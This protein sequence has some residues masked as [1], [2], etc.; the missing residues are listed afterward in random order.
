M[1][2]DTESQLQERVIKT[3]QG[4]QLVTTT[5]LLT[6]WADFFFLEQLEVLGENPTCLHTY[7]PL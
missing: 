7:G 1:V 6:S 3:L 4:L 5:K 2:R